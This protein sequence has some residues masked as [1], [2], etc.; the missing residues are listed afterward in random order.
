M[1]TRAI[2]SMRYGNAPDAHARDLLKALWEANPNLANYVLDTQGGL[3]A[4]IQLLVGGRHLDFLQ[5]LDTPVGDVD[6]FMLIPP[7]AGG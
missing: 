2:Y 5:G 4:G 1:P 6:D 3:N 7:L